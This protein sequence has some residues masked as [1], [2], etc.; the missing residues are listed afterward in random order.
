MRTIL[1]TL[2]A[3]AMAL[4]SVAV[5]ARPTEAAWVDGWFTFGGNTATQSRTFTDGSPA[6]TPVAL[7]LQKKAGSQKCRAQVVVTKGGY[8]WRSQYIYKYTRTESRGYAGIIDWPDGSKEATVTVKTN[9]RCIYQVF[10][11]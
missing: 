6:R 4:G 8:V 9:G 3:A 7:Y 2:L 1:A 11:K 10:A 5:D